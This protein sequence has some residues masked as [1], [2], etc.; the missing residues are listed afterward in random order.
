LTILYIALGGM[1]GT[2]ARLG[3]DRLI[4]G[5]P[6]TLVVNLTGS[7]VLGFIVHYVTRSGGV[8]PDLRSA[9]TIGFCGAYTTMSTFSYESLALI[10]QGEYGR[11]ALYMAVTIIGCVTAVFGGMLLAERIVQIAAQQPPG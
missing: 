2:L 3:I 10:V 5:R 1:T 4:P 11:A 6:A 9:L 8:S 7:L